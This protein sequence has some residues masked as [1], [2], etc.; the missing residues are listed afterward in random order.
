MAKWW[1]TAV[2]A[3]VSASSEAQEKTAASRSYPFEGEVTA[4]NLYVRMFPKGDPNASISTGVL[5][6]GDKVQVVGEQAEYWQ[7]RPPKGSTVWVSAKSLKKEGAAATSVASDVPLRLDSRVTADQVGALKDGEAVKVVAEHMGWFKIESPDC[8]KY[9]V[10]K[11]H[12]KAASGGVI[13]PV[14]PPK[15]EPRRAR[16]APAGD[17]DLEARREVSVAEALIDEQKRLIDGGQVKQVDFTE[18]VKHYES[19]VSLAKTDAV[20]GQAE[21]GIKRY[22]ALSEIWLKTKAELEAQEER[23]RQAKEAKPVEGQKTYAMTGFVDTTGLLFKRP[24]THKLV[25]GGK[26]VCFLKTK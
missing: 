10:G 12:V 21:Q 5:H 20:R 3:V 17:E 11:K 7:I 14:A 4:E 25:M 18:V 16:P 6:H 22:K 24:G 13:A 2:Q 9:F 26:I 1:I 19:A 23:V 8:V 15:D